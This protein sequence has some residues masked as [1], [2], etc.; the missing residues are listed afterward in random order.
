MT[1]ALEAR[2]VRFDWPGRP[3]LRGIDLSVA[4]GEFRV[5]IGPNG[6]GKTTLLKIL[7][8][9]LAP[10][11][12]TVRVGGQDLAAMSRREAAR[13]IAWVPQTLEM[14]FP[15]TVRDFALLSRYPH[16]APLSGPSA[17]DRAAVDGA[18]E[19]LG[20]TDLGDRPLPA[21]SGGERQRALLAAALAQDGT[22]LLADEPS[23]ALD[24]RHAL[25]I[26]EILDRVRQAED[27]AV[28]AV[29]HDLVLAGRFAD[30]VTLVAGGTVE[31]DGSR[32]EVLREDVLERVY[33][34]PWQRV[35]DS[36][37]IPARRR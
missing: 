27:R 35:D 1:P 3:V 29:T 6:A 7:A 13:R 30:R 22:V 37:L 36:V 18:L 19:R 20:M 8:G 33:G 21:L 25:E 31:A 34:V 32:E 26:Y 16:H 12:G 2:G 10:V 17:A 4:P 5:V 28:V 24:P 11:A 15:F 9:L 23:A 14:T